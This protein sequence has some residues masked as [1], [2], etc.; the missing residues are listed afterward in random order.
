MEKFESI[1]ASPDDS[2]VKHLPLR[3]RLYQQ[4]YLRAAD[5]VLT[6]VGTTISRYVVLAAMDVLPGLTGTKLAELTFQAPQSIMDITKRLESQGY[7]ERRPGRGR[8]ITHH[9]TPSGGELL[10]RS[11]TVMN[12]FHKE[13]FDGFDTTHLDRLV[14]DFGVMTSNIPDVK[15]EQTS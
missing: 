9:L 12:E 11:R 15:A 2:G 10:G 8:A 7:I 1:L 3:I 14:R 4:T 13:I 6:K 5:L